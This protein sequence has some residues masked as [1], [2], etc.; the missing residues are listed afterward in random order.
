MLTD[1]VIDKLS[2]YYG[3][4]IR[5]NKNGT[6]KEMQDAI[7]ASYYHISTN[8]VSYH[9]FCPKGTES[10]CFYRR[11]TAQG[12]PESVKDHRK[13]NLFLAKIP[14]EKLQYIKLVYKDLAN[15]TLLKRCLKGATH[16]PNESL[17]SKVW[18]K[19]HKI[20]FYS[21]MRV[22]FLVQHSALEHTSVMKQEAS[23]YIS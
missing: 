9:H 18:S 10:W 15:P 8:D 22:K 21:H 19:C 13:K 17:H 4:A 11:A 20:K 7:W 2:S 23:C 5:D 14:P 16:N 12:L 6:M 3:K 1:E